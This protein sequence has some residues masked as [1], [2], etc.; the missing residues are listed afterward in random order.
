MQGPYVFEKGIYLPLYVCT[1]K[2]DRI[3]KGIEEPVDLKLVKHMYQK[4]C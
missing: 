1:R 3:I 4:M 2:Y